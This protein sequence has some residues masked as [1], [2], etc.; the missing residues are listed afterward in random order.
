MISAKELLNNESVELRMEKL[1]CVELAGTVLNDKYKKGIPNA[2]VTLINKCTGEKSVVTTNADGTF[3]FCLAQDCD[4]EVIAS[5][6]SFEETQTMVS[7][8]NLGNGVTST[9]VKMELLPE[10]KPVTPKVNTPTKVVTAPTNVVTP[11]TSTTVISAPTT[12]TTTTTTSNTTSNNN[13]TTSST[14]TSNSTLEVGGVIS[15][16]NI[17]YDYDKWNIRADA[18]VELD[19]IVNMM[20]ASPN[21]EISL[22]SHTDSRG[23]KTY[24]QVLSSKRANSARQYLISRGIQSHRVKAQGFGESQLRNHCQDNVK[25]SDDEHQVNRRTEVKI[26]RT[27]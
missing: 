12:T 14:G 4:F 17:Y 9:K 23:D 11:S 16:N 3:D 1:K 10:V 8:I 13:T 5:K 24:N 7:T 19:Q 26:T 2:N 20:K 27:K 22:S 21:M 18:S 6:K 15:L 25:C